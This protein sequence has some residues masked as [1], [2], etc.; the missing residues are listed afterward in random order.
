MDRVDDTHDQ[1][2]SYTVSALG[3]QNASEFKCV[4]VFI[5]VLA[6]YEITWQK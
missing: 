2:Q 1:V 6:G 3:C 5:L 4:L